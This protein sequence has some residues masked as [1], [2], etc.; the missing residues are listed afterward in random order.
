MKNAPLL[1]FA[2]ALFIAL[3]LGWLIVIGRPIL[4]P[5]VT[6][7]IAVYVMT[8]ASNALHRQ[9]V[10]RHL[11]LSILRFLLLSVFAAAVVTL[12]VM[13]A[14]TVREIG[15]VAPVYEEN[16]DGL[17]EGI[18]AQFELDRQALWDEIRAV[19]IGSFDLRQVFLGLLG[20][21]TNV[22]AAV[23]LVV[24]Y[25][26][27]LMSERAGFEQKVTAA[28]STPEQSE[29]VME[30]V[31]EV[32]LKI[33][34]YLAVKTLINVILGVVSFVLLWAHGTDFALFWAVV[35]G[36]LNYIPY[37]G[38]I[39]GVF[40]PVVLSFAQFG[41]LPQTLSLAVFLTAT[42]VIV[43][44][45]VEPRFIGRQINLSPLVVL[46]ALSVWTALWGIPGA[47]LAVPMTSMMAI[48]LGSFQST[49]F[50]SVLLAERTSE[51][52]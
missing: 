33:S 12:A 25:S 47:I 26:A 32:N 50:L 49:R 17:L 22:G 52:T 41:S 19:T 42:Q 5:I 39:I 48:V 21:F 9:P 36:L 51:Q 4:L 38:S 40:F 11:N 7:I 45:V 6:A 13:T 28:F 2:L 46:I 30:I 35:I 23:F 14:A 3:V 31:R 20:G 37:V 8:S 34:D 43:G 24:I 10:L 27:F 16:L 15:A 18:A 44:N 29:K 1:N